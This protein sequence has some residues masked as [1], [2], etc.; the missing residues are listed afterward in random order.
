MKK[1]I[2]TVQAAPQGG[3]YV[4]DQSDLRNGDFR[5]IVAAFTTLGEALDF[6]AK[7]MG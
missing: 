4:L 7:M 2:M 5:P 1:T 6:I 3:F